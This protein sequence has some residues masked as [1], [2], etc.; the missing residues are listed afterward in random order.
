VATASVVATFSAGDAAIIVALISAFAAIIGPVVLLLVTSLKRIRDLSERA[1]HNTQPNG[2]P[3]KEGN[4]GPPSPY[5]E[6]VATHEYMIGQI[7]GVAEQAR[8]AAA[9][10]VLARAAVKAHEVRT[11]A[12]AARVDEGFAEAKEARQVLEQR[13]DANIANGATFAAGIIAAALGPPLDVLGRLDALDG[14]NTAG[15]FRDR[16]NGTTHDDEPEPDVDG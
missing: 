1:V 9:E 4:V 14:Q 3:D 16:I 2:V 5:D 7:H 12:I 15:P 8:A 6:L 11:A 13:L 10:A